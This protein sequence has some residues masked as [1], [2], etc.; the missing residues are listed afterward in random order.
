VGVAGRFVFHFISGVVFF[1]MYAW[2]G[3][4]SVLHSLAYNAAYLVPAFVISIIIYFIAL[5]LLLD[6]YL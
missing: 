4:N 2:P 1:Y 5:K 6:L 3:W